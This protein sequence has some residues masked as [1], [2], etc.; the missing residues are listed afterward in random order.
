MRKTLILLF[1]FMAAICAVILIVSKKTTLSSNAS[2][3]SFTLSGNKSGV[4]LDKSYTLTI[5]VTAKED[6]QG[7]SGLLTYDADMMEYEA[8]N[9]PAIVGSNGT[10][11]LSD[12]FAKPTREKTYKLKFKACSVGECHFTL[13][14]NYYTSYEDLAVQAVG[15]STASV[16]ILVNDGVEDDSTLSELLIGAGQ[17][18]PDWDSDCYEYEVHVPKDTTIFTYSAAPTAKDATIVSDGPEKLAKGR[19]IYKITVTAPS[20]DESVYTIAVIRE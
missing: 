19:N 18:S 6:M 4:K 5:K 1:I 3:E 11:T 13:S 15:S 20:G 10:L 9:Q 16:T 2:G 14:D 17:L 7:V 8:Q 12:T